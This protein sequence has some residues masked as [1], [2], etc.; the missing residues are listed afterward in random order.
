MAELPLSPIKRLMKQNGAERVS[1][2]AVERM[3]D[4]VEDILSEKAQ[5]AAT[6]TRHADRKTVQASDVKNAF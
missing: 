4:E 6:W 5:E 3:R 2:A 1:E